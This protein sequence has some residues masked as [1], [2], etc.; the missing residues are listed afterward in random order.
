[1]ESTDEVSCA[2]HSSSGIGWQHQQ[3]EHQIRDHEDQDHAGDPPQLGL[4]GPATARHSPR[5]PD[6]EEVEASRTYKRLMLEDTASATS[7]RMGLSKQSRAAQV[8]PQHQAAVATGAQHL[9]YCIAHSYCCLIVLVLHSSV[10]ESHRYI[11]L[12]R[13]YVRTEG[14]PLLFARATGCRYKYAYDI[15]LL[16]VV[17][18]CRKAVRTSSRGCGSTGGYTI[19]TRRKPSALVLGRKKSMSVTFFVLCAYCKVPTCSNYVCSPS[20]VSALPTILAGGA[21]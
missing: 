9:L 2:P 10:P 15:S 21:W 3:Q 19:R 18:N 14:V 11:V 20:W 13:T 6:R 8:R 12:V 16:S 17:R 1:M 7:L 4:A 5:R